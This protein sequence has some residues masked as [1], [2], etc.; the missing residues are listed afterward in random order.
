MEDKQFTTQFI[1]VLAFLFAFTIIILVI[2]NSMYNSEDKLTDSRVQQ[3][4]AD[5]IQPVGQVY[6]GEVPAAAGIVEAAEVKA[7]AVALSG[8]QVYQQVC[9][10]CHTSGVMNAPMLG[11][12]ASWEARLVKGTET[13]YSNAINGI[14]TMPA[15]GGR[16]DLAD[17]AI[18]AAVDHLIGN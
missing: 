11:D 6:V 8:D 15:K 17:D 1:A 16:A 9:A 14:G 3:D 10:S 5:R 12:V 4:V 13:L 7:V 2:A 18:K